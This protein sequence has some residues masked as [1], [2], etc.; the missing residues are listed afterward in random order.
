MSYAPI[1]TPA[2]LVNKIYQQ[3]IDE[4]TRDTPDIVTEAIDAAIAEAKMYLT[5]FDLV[6]LF[7]D[8]TATEANP[9]GVSAT[10][11]DVNLTNM[12]KQLA[13][14]QLL[15]LANPNINYDDAKARYEMAIKQFIRIQDGKSAPK[16]PYND[17]TKEDTPPSL[18]VYS[19]SGPKR[20][21]S[22]Y[23]NC[24]NPL[25]GPGNCP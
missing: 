19:F 23:F 5:R 9:S 21:N 16:W 10:F 6:A 2:T 13:I 3:Q 11:T 1:I 4:I 18:E 12:I 25:D 8:P 15:A 22:G 17:V 7:G 20:N 24:P 14:W